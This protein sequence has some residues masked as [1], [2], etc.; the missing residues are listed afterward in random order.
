MWLGSNLNQVNN[1][2]NLN[3]VHKLSLNFEFQAI[4]HETLMF[5]QVSKSL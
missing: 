1:Q 3:H 4:F 5:N 2:T